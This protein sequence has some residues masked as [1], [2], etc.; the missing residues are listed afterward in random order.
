MIDSRAGSRTDWLPGLRD[1]IRGAVHETR[2]ALNGVVVNIEV[3]RSR[4]ARAAA[5]GATE[6]DVLSFA[7]QA[8]SEAEVAARLNEGVG[9]LLSLMAASVDS[10]DRMRCASEDDSSAIGFDVESAVADQLLP[11][12]EALGAAAGFTAE[13]RVGAVILRFPKTSDTEFQK[14]NESAEDSHR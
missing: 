13:K 6:Q 4:L 12:L 11:R 7:E 14:P 8:A 5:A 9:A 10:N 3:V 1:I 2:N